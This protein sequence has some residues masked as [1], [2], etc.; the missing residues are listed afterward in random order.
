V[1]P[2]R[3][4]PGLGVSSPPRQ[5]DVMR[6]FVLLAAALL[7]LAGGS[8][9]AAETP[10]PAI[11]AQPLALPATRAALREGRPLVILAFGSSSTEGAGASTP[12]R[13]YPARLE[14]RLHAAMPGV[15]LT[16]LNRGR[17][18]EDVTEMLARLDREVI[19][20]SPTL[21][22]W[23]AGANAVLKGMP[24]ETF[25]ALM[26]EGLARLR[27]TGTDV[28]LMD[29][30]R[31]PRILAS[32]NHPVFDALMI[33]LAAERQVPLFSRAALMRRWEAVGAP[34]SAF[35]SE[36]GLHHNDRGYECLA[37]ALAESVVASLHLSARMARR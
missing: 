9:A 30:Q 34:A 26:A 2:Q 31:A 36:D 1:F 25:H 16:V 5:H 3:T 7:G 35:L 37:H 23:Q 18:G 27:A 15:P 32:P 29:S 4:G 28:V 21:V 8:P 11:Q 14:A 20:S 12:D 19:A 17:S 13:T 22:I 6:W 33:G 24:P 10:C